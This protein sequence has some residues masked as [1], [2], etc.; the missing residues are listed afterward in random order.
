MNFYSVAT[1]LGT[2][3]AKTQFNA[4]VLH[5]ILLHEGDNILFWF[6]CSEGADLTIT[7]EDVAVELCFCR[8]LV[9]APLI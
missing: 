6:R 7:V 5:E 9:L 3:T 4:T 2:P 1:L 8:L